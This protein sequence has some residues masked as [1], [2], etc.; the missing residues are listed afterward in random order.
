MNR[1]SRCGSGGWPL[2]S[3]D[4]EKKAGLP[5]KM[6][7]SVSENCTIGAIEIIVCAGLRTHA[8]VD[9]GKGIHDA[10]QARVRSERA[11]EGLRAQQAVRRLGDLLHRLEEQS[12]AIEV[13]A[14]VGTLDAF[15]E[16]RAL[17]PGLRKLR[18]GAFREFGVLP[19]M[20]TRI[21]LFRCGKYLSSSISR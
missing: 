17:S 21:S 8:A 11:E 1:V 16:I 3:V 10:A 6:A 18:G 12:V 19:S 2:S 14:A 9:E 13:R 20:T 4:H 7:A 15:E 5:A